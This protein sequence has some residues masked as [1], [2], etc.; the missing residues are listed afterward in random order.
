M[1]DMSRS[2]RPP[3]RREFL[4]LGTGIFVALSL[5]LSLRRH[6][7]V[8]RRSVPLMGTIAEVQVAHADERFAQHAID[9]AMAELMRVERLMT[10]FRAD[11][12]IGRANLGAARDAVAISAE[13]AAVL[14][15]A[16]RWSV[17]SDGRFD[18]AIGSA[19]ELWDV[20]NRREPPLDGRV[21]RVAARGFWRHV[22]IGT[23]RGA[24]AVR[25]GHP[26]L[27]LDLGAIAKGH[28]IDRAVVVLRELGVAHAI[29]TV[30]G[31]LYTIGQSPAGGPWQVGIRSPHDR[32]ALAATLDVSDRAVTTSGDY[33]RFFRW[34]GHTYHHLIDPET[35]APRIT[36]MHSATV[37]GA[38]CMNADAAAT[39]AFGLPHDQALAIVRRRIDG[40]EVIPL[41]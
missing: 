19:S 23:H 11:S 1:P 9:R 25:Y 27:H 29:V 13:T 32:T 36:P 39:A 28:G 3:T 5:P 18:P 26:D 14:E 4:T 20:L 22:D 8:T 2:T 35:G 7:T 31:D 15:A 40:A 6:F 30:G 21:Q 17:A 10:R 34:H 16:L 33:E 12:D 24:P 38:D 41:T 37:L